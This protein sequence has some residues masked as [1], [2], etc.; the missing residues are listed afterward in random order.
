MKPTFT[1]LLLILLLPLPRLYAQDFWETLPFP[2]T[3]H[4]RCMAVNNQGHIF[5]GAGS[6]NTIGGIYR[7]IDGGLNWEFIFNMGD[8]SVLSIA[9][10]VNGYIYIGKTGFNQFQVST[11]NGE[12]W[13]EIILPSVG[14]IL[15]IHCHGTDTIYVSRWA[16]FGA[17]LLRSPNSGQTWEEIFS[18]VNH[19]SEHV[20]DIAIS[21][22]GTIYLGL[23]SYQPDMGGVYKSEDNGSVCRGVGRGARRGLSRVICTEKWRRGMD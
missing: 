7:S 16:D 22:S 11:D 15:K 6:N 10:N 23:K 2:D 5:I 9:I 17:C 8:F 14:N 4:V 21:E 1:F 12:T 13:E 3:A 19:S 18:T 20:K